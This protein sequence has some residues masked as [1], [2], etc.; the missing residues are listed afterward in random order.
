[1]RTGQGREGS[2]KRRPEVTGTRPV[3]S[4]PR[5]GWSWALWVG[6][7]FE[8]CVPLFVKSVVD[9]FLN[10]GTLTK[11]VKCSR[12]VCLFLVTDEMFRVRLFLVTAMLRVY[13]WLLRDHS[14]RCWGHHTGSLASNPKREPDPSLTPC[15]VAL[16]PGAR[17]QANVMTRG[18]PRNDPP[19]VTTTLERPGMAG[20]GVEGLGESAK[21]RPIWG[22]ISRMQSLPAGPRGR[23]D[24]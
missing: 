24:A 16:A 4:R 21:T 22:A 2:K 10:S 1:M 8:Q 7:V 20:W 17:P 23:G 19:G 14:W 5:C 15:P 12:S 9:S 3:D 11:K 6:M 18:R 13:S